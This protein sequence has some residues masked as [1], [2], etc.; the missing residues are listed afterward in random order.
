MTPRCDWKVNEVKH[1]YNFDDYTLIIDTDSSKSSLVQSTDAGIIIEEKDESYRIY[2]SL[3]KQCS[4]FTAET[5][6]ISTALKIIEN[7]RDLFNNVVIC[8]C[9]L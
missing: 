5:I 8:C 4:I 9:L 7:R 2:C 1:R 6:A 3:P